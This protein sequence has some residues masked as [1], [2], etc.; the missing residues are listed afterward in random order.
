MNRDTATKLN[1]SDFWQICHQL[2][3]TTNYTFP[4]PPKLGVANGNHD[5][6]QPPN[7]NNNSNNI[8]SESEEVSSSSDESLQNLFAKKSRAHR[9]LLTSHANP[10]NTQKIYDTIDF[11]TNENNKQ[12][13]LE[14]SETS[15]E[16]ICTQIQ[17]TSD[18]DSDENDSIANN[19]DDLLMR[20]ADNVHQLKRNVNQMSELNGVC[21]KNGSINALDAGDLIDFSDD[22]TDQGESN[23]N[24][25][26]HRDKNL[27][28][29]MTTTATMAKTLACVQ[30]KWKKQSFNEFPFLEKFLSISLRCFCCIV[31]ELLLMLLLLFLLLTR[32]LIFMGIKNLGRH[33][34][35]ANIFFFS[36][37]HF[38]YVFQ[39][40]ERLH[41][42]C[43]H[44][45]GFSFT[46]Q[47]CCF[48]LVF[49]FCVINF[50]MQNA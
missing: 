47:I 12:K 26:S 42:P 6:H 43:T 23:D 16:S 5:F 21:N 8:Q 49:F 39:I 17:T 4:A 38:F 30:G 41:A 27:K 37:N 31:G 15:D 3:P 50:E 14:T 44:A 19:A 11:F 9:K 10:V 24:S 22:W 28:K 48:M 2:H 32:R 46:R 40:C 45:F 7:N 25:R 1:D 36:F 35:Y 18:M 33:S 29:V 20:L 34:I 13:S